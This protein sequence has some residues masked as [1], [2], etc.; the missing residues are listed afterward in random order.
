[1]IYTDEAEVYLRRHLKFTHNGFISVFETIIRELGGL[2][3]AYALSN[4]SIFKAKAKEL[5]DKLLPAFQEG[6]LPIG[7]ISLGTGKTHRAPGGLVVLAEAGTSLMELRYLSKITGDDK[8]AKA[9]EKVMDILLEGGG[10]L[11]LVPNVWRG[12]RPPS[13]KLTRTINRKKYNV[14]N[15]SSL[16]ENVPAVSRISLGGS[17]DSYY[18]YLLKAW[19]Q[20]GKR[21]KIKNI[22]TPGSCPCTR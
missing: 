12:T 5:G 10:N 1:L 15:S 4:K 11:G 2:L 20:S 8:Y 16:R 19:I 17:A 13:S 7:S 6:T 22:S 21:N 18:E 14:H 3:S 9:S